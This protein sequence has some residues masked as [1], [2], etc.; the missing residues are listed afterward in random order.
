MGDKGELWWCGDREEAKWEGAALLASLGKKIT[1]D[2]G[3]A[4]EHAQ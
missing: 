2:W 3:E 4:V 1:M